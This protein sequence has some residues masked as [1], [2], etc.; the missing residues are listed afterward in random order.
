ME[1]TPQNTGGIINPRDIAED[2]VLAI[3]LDT[4]RRLVTTY[5]SYPATSDAL[6]Q[7]RASLAIAAR[8]AI[9]QKEPLEQ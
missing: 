9:D 6:S 4:L 8:R 3:D 5:N 2:A 1:I 7:L